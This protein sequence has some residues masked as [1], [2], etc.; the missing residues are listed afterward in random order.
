[1]NISRYLIAVLLPASAVIAQHA[2]AD[3]NTTATA[4]DAEP[5]QV[6]TVVVSPAPTAQ[7]EE[8]AA[9]K[10]AELWDKTKEETGEAASAAAE[11][12][13]TQGKKILKGTKKGVEKGTD[14]VVDGSKKAWEATK[15]TSKKAAKATANALETTGEKINKA[16]DGSDQTAPVSEKS[17][18]SSSGS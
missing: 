16:L 11:F 13:K 7:S 10:A 3:Q 18:E 12:S 2:A 8:T 17:V 14:A 6:E 15:T 9:D 5:V 1:M 4:N